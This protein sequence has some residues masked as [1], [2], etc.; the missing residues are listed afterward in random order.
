MN[1]NIETVR[2]NANAITIN[3]HHTMKK[4]NNNFEEVAED[5][6]TAVKNAKQALKLEQSVL[7]C[8]Y[9]VSKS[10]LEGSAI[11]V[12][13]MVRNNLFKNMTREIERK[14][15]K[16]IAIKQYRDC[17]IHEIQLLIMPPSDLKHI[18]EYCIRQMPVEAINK[19]RGVK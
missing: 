17:E 5:I 7:T 1:R 6:L 11:D 16:Q 2:S 14:H 15:E 10:C 19:I 18:V 8:S 9:S 12:S 4:E 3:L 13:I